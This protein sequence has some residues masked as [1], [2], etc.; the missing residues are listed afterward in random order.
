MPEVKTTATKDAVGISVQTGIDGVFGECIEAQYISD[1]D[2]IVVL[3]LAGRA[4]GEPEVFL[5]VVCKGK[6][7]IPSPQFARKRGE[8]IFKNMDWWIELKQPE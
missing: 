1:D 3:A 5:W 8:H 6:H 2:G 4:K 7:Y